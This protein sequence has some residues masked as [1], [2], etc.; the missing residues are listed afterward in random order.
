MTTPQP[1]AQPTHT[2]AHAHAQEP[3]H[4]YALPARLLAQLNIPFHTPLLTPRQALY[5][6]YAIVIWMGAEAAW[7]HARDS[8]PMVMWD[9]WFSFL[10]SFIGFVWYCRDRDARGYPHSRWLNVCMAGLGPLAVL[11]YLLRSR[12]R[13]QRARALLG[14]GGF[15]LAEVALMLLGAFS[16][17]MLALALQS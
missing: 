3:A 15:L 4:A 12:P 17:T 14:L 16:A 8:L 9:Y 13:G 10:F 7:P 5:A 2:Q 6:L 1:V 11:Y